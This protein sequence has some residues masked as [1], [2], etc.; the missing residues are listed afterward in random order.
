MKKTR[1]ETERTNKART[2][3]LL[4]VLLLFATLQHSMNQNVYVVTLPERLPFHTR[5]SI[6]RSHSLH[7][8]R[9]LY[10]T[11][12]TYLLSA[13]PS[14][15]N[16]LKRDPHIITID[17]LHPTAKSSLFKSRNQT[18]QR[19]LDLLCHGDRLHTHILP[20]KIASDL[21]TELPFAY[22]HPVLRT[23]IEIEVTTLCLYN[24]PDC[25]SS[26]SRSCFLHALLGRD[27]ALVDE[28]ATQ[29]STRLLILR[30]PPNQLCATAHRLAARHHI[31]RIERREAY[32]VYNAYASAALQSGASARVTKENAPVWAHGLLGQ[33]E[34]VGVG[35]TGVDVDS[36]YFREQANDFVFRKTAHSGSSSCDMSR[37]KIVFYC[38]AQSAAFGDDA[39]RRGGGH[40]THV[41]GTIAG[42]HEA[43]LN[44]SGNVEAL[45]E[46][47]SRFREMNG[48]AP[49]A[50][51]AVNDI[52]A[53]I[54]PL[55]PP[56][57][58]ATSP[59]LTEPYAKAGM[60]IHS[61][62]W[63]CGAGRDTARTCNKYSA[64]ARSM[65]GTFDG[66][67]ARWRDSYFM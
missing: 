27:A 43:A 57:D 60:R 10:R 3:Y 50:R 15:V 12:S 42:M 63:G 49:M 26:A 2:M 19:D 5:R 52:G 37:R 56:A 11:P 32:T 30:I 58:V 46:H 33:G 59:F 48:I 54:G 31:V 21:Q 51:L 9:H 14:L 45:L 28:T 22:T 13:P 41:A 65:D 40:G 25:V 17:R 4:R 53:R 24:A 47:M 35:D 1:R 20:D 55:Y 39:S 29:G 8:D 67:A 6:W 36:C 61:N 64:L 7:N 62:S 18:L 44:H 16:R 38:T 23:A 34:V 66:R